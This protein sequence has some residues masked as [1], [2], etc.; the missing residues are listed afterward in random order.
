LTVDLGAGRL[1]VRQ[2]A[3]AGQL[4]PL[5][6]A[7]AAATLRVPPPLVARLNA[8]RALWAPNPA[9]L[10]FADELGAPLDDDVLRRALRRLL[11]RLGIRR[12]GLHGFRH[13]CALAMAD[14]GCN[15][16]AMRRAMRHASLRTTAIYLTAAPE[17]IAAA[18]EAGAAAAKMPRTESAAPPEMPPAA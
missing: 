1:E 17:D 2:Q 11:D 5:K 4:R 10:L 13:T 18:L 15:P 7:S 9:G 16:E 6:A 3:Q 8:W 12:R 14:A